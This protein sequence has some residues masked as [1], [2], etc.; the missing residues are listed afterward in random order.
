MI[1]QSLT[2][3]R[4]SG[5]SPRVAI[6]GTGPGGITVARR[7]AEAGVPSL[8][9]D[10]GDVEYTDE[11]QR[12]YQGE[13][14]GDPYFELDEARLRH[15]GGTSGHWS[16]WCR[17][18]D[19]HDFDQHAWIPNSGWP[20]GRD[21]IDPYVPA[22]LET[23]GLE[24]FRDDQPL[25]EDMS[26]IHLIRS[27]PVRFADKYGPEIE[28]SE[29]IALVLNAYVTDLVAKEGEV[30]A[31]NIQ[32]GPGPRQ[33]LEAPTFVVATGGIENSRLL[34]W[35]NETSPYPVVPD[36][37]S[38]GRYWMEHPE[39]IAG[40][41]IIRDTD[42]Y[43]KDEDGGAYFAPTVAAMEK[44]EIGNFHAFIAPYPYGTRTK[45]LIVDLACTA[46]AA[47][48][49]LARQMGERIVCGTRVSVAW[50]QAPEFSNH[51]ALSA[52]DRDFAGVPRPELHWR[53]G[54]FERRT[55]VEGFKMMG[56][57]L[58]DRRIGRL[59]AEDWLRDGADYPDDDMIAGYH[60]MGGTRMSTDPAKGVVN[61]DCRVHGMSNLYVAGS[62]IFTTGGYANPTTTIVAF[63]H[64]LGDHLAQQMT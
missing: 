52:D 4:D 31:A 20:I 16:G 46:P 34:L 53:K 32:S 13:V 10:A 36:A 41:A 30:V 40:E 37:T 60:H 6:I 26:R 63:A 29:M 22:A 14:I 51:V 12:V 5:F 1:F 44:A 19:A 55:L 58:I 54:D 57:A 33:R 47:A 59:R 2:Q 35:S 56:A 18:L 17:L 38:L 9:L 8:L 48:H 28:S 64:R 7:L 21:A 39:Y 42:A 49:W 45:Q 27:D 50:E 15:F 3:Y 11:S 23:L 61:A 62:S 24:P 25:T 43:W